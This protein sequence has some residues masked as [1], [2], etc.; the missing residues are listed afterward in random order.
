MMPGLDAWW[1]EQS[2]RKPRRYHAWRARHG[3]PSVHLGSA[4][5]EAA[6]VEREIDGR[7]AL[8]LDGERVVLQLPRKGAPEGELA[9]LARL[10]QDL[11]RLAA[12]AD[13][14]SLRSLGLTSVRAYRVAEQAGVAIVLTGGRWVV[15]RPQ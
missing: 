12:A 1:A 2:A 8:V 6:A 3:R 10:R 14:D 7:P 5:E 4:D 13:G 9:K 11:R 15:R